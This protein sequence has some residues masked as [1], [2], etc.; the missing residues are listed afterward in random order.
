MNTNVRDGPSYTNKLKDDIKNT[1]NTN[2]MLLNFLKE[3][4]IYGRYVKNVTKHIIKYPHLANG[5]L[6]SIR[7]NYDPI[8][9]GFAWAT[10]SERHNFWRNYN[11][12]YKEIKNKNN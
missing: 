5:I 4:K 7:C 3:K 8:S 1:I 12:T 10:T 9:H 11:N 6:H 2:K